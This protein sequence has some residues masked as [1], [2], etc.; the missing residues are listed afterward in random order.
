MTTDLVSDEVFGDLLAS[1]GTPRP[2][3][4]SRQGSGKRESRQRASRA[5]ERAQEVGKRLSPLP[6]PQKSEAAL[7]GQKSGVSGLP[8]EM[9]ERELAELFG[10]N[11]STVRSKAAEGVFV[12]T[13]PAH[14]DVEACVRGYVSKLREV[15]S[16][17]GSGGVHGDNLKAEKLRLTKAQA[18]KE[19]A[20]VARE[21]G[22]LVEAAA[23]TRE[24]SNLLRDLRNALLAVPS[25]V[26]AALPHLTATDIAALESEMRR[27]LEDFA[28]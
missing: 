16:R 15:A 3:S 25:R 4:P 2:K 20:R 24:W 26:G 28:K 5:T 9:H 7:S 1:N 19:E 18:D 17:A 23:V 13:R 8:A 10:I 27:A 11:L 6:V 12:R 14:Y 22:E 21:R